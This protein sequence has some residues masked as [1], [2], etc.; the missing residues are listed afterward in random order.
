[1]KMWGHFET[2]SFTRL[3]FFRLASIIPAIGNLGKQTFA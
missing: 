2:V 1:M 3:Q